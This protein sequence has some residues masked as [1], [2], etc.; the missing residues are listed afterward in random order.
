VSPEG[1]TEA[2]EALQKELDDERQR[3]QNHLNE[4][5]R[6]EQRYDNLKEELSLSKVSPPPPQVFLF[7]SGLKLFKCRRSDWFLSSVPTRP[8]EEPV[9]PEQPGVGLQLPVRLQLGGGR[10][11]GLHPAGGGESLRGRGVKVGPRGLYLC[12]LT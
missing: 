9:Q 10:H 11:R 6:L 2:Q 7:L 4:F 12:V 5:T 3:Y 1:S 8:P